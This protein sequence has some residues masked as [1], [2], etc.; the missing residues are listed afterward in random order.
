MASIISKKTASH[1]TWGE[2]CD[3]WVLAD[4]AGLSVKQENM[5]SGTKEE[6]HFHSIAQQ[7]FFIL[8]GEATFYCDG[9]KYIVIANTGIHIPP[10]SKHYI[11]NETQDDLEFLIIS[12]P[13]TTNDRTNI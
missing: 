3:S 12:Q 7:F 9:K 11:A 6:L 5:L 10:G 1:Y 8:K 2:N 13:T 4:T